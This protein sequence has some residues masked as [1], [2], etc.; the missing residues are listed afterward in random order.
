VRRRLPL[1]LLALATAAADAARAQGVLTLESPAADES[2]TALPLLELRGHAGA[3]ATRGHDVV[4]AID[5]S[6]S[7]TASSGRDLDGD[8]PNGR[9]SAALWRE[10]AARAPEP[11]LLRPLEALDLEDSVLFAELAA[12]EALVERVDPRSFRIGIV[13]FSDEAHVAA[14]LGSRRARLRAVLESLRRGGFWSG[15]KGTNFSEAIHTSLAELRPPPPPADPNAKDG[16]DAPPPRRASEHAREASILL[17]SDGAPTRPVHGN[18]AQQ[19]SV[20]AAQDAAVAGVRIYPFALGSEAEPALEIYQALAAA[21]G[22]RYERIDRPGDAV[23]RLRVVDLADLA[24]L[25]VQNVTS[26]Q[27]GRAVRVFPDGAFDAFLPLE[28]GPNRVRVTAAAVDGTRSVLERTVVYR[29]GPGGDADL[30]AR[31]RA[32]LDEL[33]RR[34]REVELWAEIERGRSIQT[35]ELELGVERPAVGADPP[36]PLPSEE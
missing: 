12:A 19:Y 23:A 6:D 11:A 2:E 21:T 17:L 3:R 13:V 30:A 28:P 34:T 22:G 14:P 7:T 27:A 8:G 20:E 16:A 29:P 1:L 31:Q 5:V 33:R 25:D 36:V 4:I 32:L 24:S 35:R 15:L 18:R 9:T 26:G 10:I